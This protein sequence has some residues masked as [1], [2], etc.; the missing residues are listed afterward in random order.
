MMIQEEY[1]QILDAALPVCVRC[2]DFSY[3]EDCGNIYCRHRLTRILIDEVFLPQ[4]TEE[5]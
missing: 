3:L 4:I 1:N 5:I 2:P